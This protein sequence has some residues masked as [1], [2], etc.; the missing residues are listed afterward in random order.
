MRRQSLSGPVQLITRVVHKVLVVRFC[1]SRKTT[2]ATLSRSRSDNAIG[3]TFHISQKGT[4]PGVYGSDTRCERIAGCYAGSRMMRIVKM[5]L[6]SLWIVVVCS[7]F[8][9]LAVG[10]TYFAWEQGWFQFA[11]G[12]LILAILAF[13]VAGATEYWSEHR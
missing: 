2:S 10:V 7:V 12:A 11:L 8:A 9:M 6:G 13:V 3:A 5:A 4:V 1:R